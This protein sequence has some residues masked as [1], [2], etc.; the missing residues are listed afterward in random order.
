MVI[1]RLNIRLLTERLQILQESLNEMRA[2][3]RLSLEEFLADKRNPRSVESYLRRALEAL[4]DIGRHILAKKAV[5]GLL[6]YKEIARRLGTE[7]ILPKALAERLVPI[8]GYRN[9]LVHFYHEV[10]DEELYEIIQHDLDD[11]EAFVRAIKHFLD[12]YQAETLPQEPQT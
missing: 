3:S 11:L 6:E 9:R 1:S 4:F 5:K 12:T 8:A 2:F 7:G 10:T